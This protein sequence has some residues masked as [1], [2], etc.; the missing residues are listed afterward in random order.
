M[1]Q[2]VDEVGQ[3][4]KELKYYLFSNRIYGF[5]GLMK[6]NGHAKYQVGPKIDEWYWNKRKIEYLRESDIGRIKHPG[7]EIS[8]DDCCEKALHVPGWC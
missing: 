6:G 4:F 5:H 1:K 2:R 7:G 3:F 8:A